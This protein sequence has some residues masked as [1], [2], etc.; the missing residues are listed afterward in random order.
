MKH[1]SN[2]AYEGGLEKLATD[3]GNLQY[4]ALQTFLIALALKI[5]HDSAADD[6]KNRKL[7]AK[8]LGKSADKLLDAAAAIGNSWSLCKIHMKTEVI[9]T[10][11]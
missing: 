3:L 4:D 5:R 6:A 7:L 11:T 2:I 8:H 1:A 9:E 10:E